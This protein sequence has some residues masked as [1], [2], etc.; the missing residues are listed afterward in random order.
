M[1]GTPVKSKNTEH[2]SHNA[3]RFYSRTRISLEI[4]TRVWCRFSNP[5]S[6]FPFKS[7]KLQ[8]LCD[9]KSRHFMIETGNREGT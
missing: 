8:I 2:E 3:T 6:N 7:Q 5:L 4:K 1:E 9:S